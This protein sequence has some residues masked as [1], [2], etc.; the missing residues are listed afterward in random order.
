[1]YDQFAGNVCLATPGLIL[2]TASSATV[3][4]A[5]TFRFKANG[6]I[7]PSITTAAAPGL[8]TAV[9]VG[10]FVNGSTTQ[11]PTTTALSAGYGR[12]YT[13]VGT[14]SSNGTATVTPTYSWLVSNDTVNNDIPSLNN[15]PQP[16]QANQ[17]AIGYVIV[18]NVSNTSFTP[19]TTALDLSGIKTT[20]VDN[21]GIVS[22]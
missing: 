6:R 10:P 2:T 20:Y 19:G 4:Y 3:T 15:A 13:L 7:S 5:N 22:V 16:N 8:L 21:F 9:M 1:M 11:V 14:L 12:T 18:Q 17:T